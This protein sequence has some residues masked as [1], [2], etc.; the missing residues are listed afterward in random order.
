MLP[1]SGPIG[2][3]SPAISDT[4]PNQK[5]GNELLD[6]IERHRRSVPRSDE[7]KNQ[8]ISGNE[9]LPFAE[10]KAACRYVGTLPPFLIPNASQPLREKPFNESKLRI[11][12]S[13]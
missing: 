4:Y 3:S 2:H 7:T 12:T 8:F 9:N 11:R 6:L 13:S 5:M 10:I 1:S